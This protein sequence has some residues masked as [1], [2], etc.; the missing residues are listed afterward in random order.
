MPSARRCPA[1][2]TRLAALALLVA[3]LSAVPARADAPA[4]S[5]AG[6]TAKADTFAQPG[7]GGLYWLENVGFDGQGGMWVSELMLNRLVRYDAAGHPGRSLPLTNPGAS[8]LG[9]DGRMYALFGDGETGFAPGVKPAGVVT[10]DPAAATPVAKPFASGLPMANGAAFD[11]AGNLYVA[12]TITS[13]AG[14]DELRPDGTLDPSFSAAVPVSGGDGL[15]I[16]GDTLYATLFS[17]P[18]ASIVK[19]PLGAPQSYSTLTQLSPGAGPPAFPDDDAIGPDGALYVATNVGRLV[20]IDPA[21]GASCVAYTTTLPIDSV[22]FAKGF[23]PYGPWDAFLTSED[24]NLLH[25]HLTPSGG[26]AAG[27]GATTGGAHGAAGGRPQ[28]RL[29][30]TPRHVRRGRRV[31]L[32]AVVRSAAASCRAGVRVRFGSRSVRTSAR[33]RAALTTRPRVRGLRTV[34]ATKAGCRTARIRLRVR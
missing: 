13:G 32:H 33:G 16:A 30:V 2:G 9:P 29:A 34:R 4:P 8:L 6:L 22:R 20:R 14:I 10:F 24:G 19:V 28:L 25:V 26:G 21:T 15:A 12:D 23:A 17:D 5:C 31:V 11:A 27:A 1:R 7:A 18:A 3:A